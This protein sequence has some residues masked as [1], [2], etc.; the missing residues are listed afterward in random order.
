MEK[1]IFRSKMIFAGTEKKKTAVWPMC[2]TIGD[3][4]VSN[5]RMRFSS[6]ETGNFFEMKVISLRK[7]EMY[8]SLYD[9]EGVPWFFKLAK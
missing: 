4:S 6:D 1:V 7:E 5:G 3:L 9:E 2:N 8:V